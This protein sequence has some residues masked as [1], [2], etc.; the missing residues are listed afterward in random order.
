MYRETGRKFWPG[1]S[2]HGEQMIGEHNAQ[3]AKCIRE[4]VMGSI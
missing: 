1:A 3:G 2:C 4:Q